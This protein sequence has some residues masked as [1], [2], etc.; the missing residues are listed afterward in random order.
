[1]LTEAELK[2]YENITFNVPENKLLTTVKAK[3]ASLKRLS[4]KYKT[5]LNYKRGSG[6]S[7]PIIVLV[8]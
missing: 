3:E 5:V 7:R 8:T 6:V 4:E 2:G 1:L